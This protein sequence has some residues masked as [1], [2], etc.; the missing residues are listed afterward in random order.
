MNKAKKWGSRV[1][2]VFVLAFACS[3]LSVLAFNEAN[4]MEGKP[5]GVALM[6]TMLMAP[7]TWGGEKARKKLLEEV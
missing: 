7:A 5:F 2:M 4:L 3:G 6:A 1:L